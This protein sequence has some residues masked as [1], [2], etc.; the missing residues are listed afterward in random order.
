MVWEETE[1]S[2]GTSYIVVG[3]VELV[4]VSAMT[5]PTFLRF[6]P[7]VGGGNMLTFEDVNILFCKNKQK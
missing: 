3:K 7:N 6:I 2:H 4:H 5:T 1:R